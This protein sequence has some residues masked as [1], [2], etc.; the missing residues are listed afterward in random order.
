[1]VTQIACAGNRRSH[2][3][4]VYSSVK[5]INWNVGAIGNNEYEGVLLLDLLKDSGFSA[6]DLMKM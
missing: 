6:D 2:T 4:K 5:G 3:R 1:M